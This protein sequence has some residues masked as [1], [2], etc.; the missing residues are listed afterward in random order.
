MTS[1]DSSSTPEGRGTTP[2][3]SPRERTEIIV[4]LGILLA[5]LMGALDQFVVLTALP[6]ILHDFGTPNSGSFVVSAYVIASAASIP[7]FSK[8][9]DLW[10]RR[11]VFLAG[12]AVFIGGSILSGLSQN[13]GTL[14]AF[15]AIQGFGTGGFLPVGLAI[16]AMIF[17]PKTRARVTGL[18][19]GV[20]A[21]A[22][23]V[24][25]VLGSTIIQYT[26]WR[27]VFYVN[28]PI[29][30]LGFAIL[31]ATLGPLRPEITRK[32]DSVGAALLLGWVASLM[33]PLYQIGESSWTWTG[34]NSLGLI[35][36]GIAMLVGFVVWE[37]RA[38]NPLVPIRLFANRVIWA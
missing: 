11:N 20:F 23:V 22:V 21:I 9:S 8:L 3:G 13:L 17:P 15:R 5:L 27:W 12:L 25:P 24:G 19:S 35:S 26:T 31:L 29:G 38:R 28:I 6:T 4:T 1:V 18:L 16:V 33:Y 10:S 37:L 36:L 2:R 34:V 32:F 7:I 14:V 30:L